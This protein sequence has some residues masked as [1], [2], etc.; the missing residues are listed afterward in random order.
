MG[1]QLFS[2]PRAKKEP[3]NRLQVQLSTT[4]HTPLRQARQ[5]AQCAKQTIVVFLEATL[6]SW[7]LSSQFWAE[8]KPAWYPQFVHG[9]KI[10]W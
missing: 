7:L 5:I 8:R 10:T 3:G 6:L 4:F 9:P 1:P 2:A